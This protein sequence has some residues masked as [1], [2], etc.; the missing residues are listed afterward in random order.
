MFLGIV[1]G[2]SEERGGYIPYDAPLTNEQKT[3]LTLVSEQTG[4][5]NQVA[6]TIKTIANPNLTYVTPVHELVGIKNSPGFQTAI[7]S[8]AENIIATKFSIL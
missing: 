3:A 6:V 7:E 4:A 5:T 2:F 8:E 1:Q